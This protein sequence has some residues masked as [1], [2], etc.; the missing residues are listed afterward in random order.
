VVSVTLVG[1]NALQL[2]LGITTPGPMIETSP[3]ASLSAHSGPGTYLVAAADMPA[4]APGE[5]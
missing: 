2:G 1:G 5:F 4:D 3:G